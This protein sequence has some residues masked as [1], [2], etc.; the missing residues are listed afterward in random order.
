MK[1]LLFLLFALFG[2]TLLSACAS[3]THYDSVSTT[4]QLNVSEL[5]LDGSEVTIRQRFQ[6]DRPLNALSSMTLAEAWISAPEM[7]NIDGIPYSLD[8]LKSVN[9][10]LV[11]EEDAP[12][13]YW[14]VVPSSKLSGQDVMFSEF[15]IG[16]LRQYVDSYQQIE[17]EIT[18]SMEPYQVMKYW[19]DVC[20]M[21]NK[22]ILEFP[23]S[24]QF[25][26]ED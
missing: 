5:P 22:C 6:F 2:F 16:D 10:F 15:N 9:I 13:I 26:M 3:E 12:S 1:K 8:M 24:M 23:L 20:D 7:A 14:L 21:N 17:L 25:K 11:E 18:L 4:V 19:R